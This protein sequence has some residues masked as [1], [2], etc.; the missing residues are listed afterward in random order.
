MAQDSSK[1]TTE[2][3]Q[4]YDY[5]FKLLII[6][7][8]ATGKSCLLRR[9]AQ[10]VFSE[11]YVATIGIDFMIK[12]VT[13]AGKTVKLQMWDTA[14]QE[15]YDFSVYLSVCLSVSL[16]PPAPSFS[17]SVSLLQLSAKRKLQICKVILLLF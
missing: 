8:K 17:L 16:W 7:D 10:D 12:E 2:Q 1:I 15:R 6:G 11:E 14:G 9:F 5:L 3:Q 4:S 13:I